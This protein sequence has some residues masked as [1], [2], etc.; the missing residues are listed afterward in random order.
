MVRRNYR[1][2]FMNQQFKQKFSKVNEKKGEKIEKL[3]VKKVD[4]SNNLYDCRQ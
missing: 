1:I 3:D 4:E 2:L